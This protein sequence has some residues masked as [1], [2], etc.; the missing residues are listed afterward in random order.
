M[1]RTV[2]IM[3]LA[4]VPALSFLPL[5]GTVAE[6][7]EMEGV[8]AMVTGGSSLQPLAPEVELIEIASG[9]AMPVGITQAGDGSGRLF[10]SQQGGSILIYDGESLLATP[11]LDISDKVV[12]CG[13]RGLLSVAFHPQYAENGYF[14]VDHTRVGDGATVI[15]RYQ[16]SSDPNVADPDSGITILTIPQP[17]S[18]H[19]GGQLQFGPDGYLY[20]G[21]GDGGGGG[22]PDNLAQDPASLLGKLLRIDVDSGSPYSIPASNPFAV[23]DGVLDEIWALGLRNPWRFSFDRM[24]GDLFIADVG[25]SAWEEVNFVAGSSVGGENYGW[26]CYE[27]DHDYDTGRECTSLGT[28]AFPILE[29][30]HDL[31]CSI[32]GGFRYRGSRYPALDKLYLYADYCS[33]RL[34]AAAQMDGLWSGALALDTTYSITTFGEDESG[35]VYLADYGNGVIYQIA[36]SSFADVPIDYWAWSSIEALNSAGLTAGCSQDPLDYCPEADITRAQM[37]VFLERGMHGS[38]YTPP[39]A[40][41]T[42]FEDVPSDHWAATWIE[43]LYADGITSG[44]SLDPLMY[45]PEDAVSRAQMAVFLERGMHWPDAFAPP[46]GGG[47]LFADVPGSYW[48]VDWIEQLYADGIT[49]GCSSDPLMYCPEDPVT[50]AEMAVFLARAFEL[51][52]P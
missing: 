50:R 28:L 30:S 43:Q 32:T 44:C 16:V 35:E 33:G 10:I 49:S 47:T 14:F 4:L 11:F 36:A 23:D 27:G 29:Y 18:N 1:N 12:C 31:G 15:E 25:Q 26:S 37:A 7:G 39:A 40:T 22:D 6:A 8:P 20:I 19:N 17:Q 42:V 41:R 13:E 5:R 3:L 34:W 2:V 48:A 52:M 38:A 46:I 45:C 51:P 9:L 24:T 21:M